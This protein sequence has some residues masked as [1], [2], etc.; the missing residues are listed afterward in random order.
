MPQPRL[1]IPFPYWEL[2]YTVEPAGKMGGKDQKLGTSTVHGAGGSGVSHSVMQGSFSVITPVFTLQVMDADDPNRIVR[3]VTPPGGLD[4]TLWT[5][6]IP[7]PGKRNSTKDSTIIFLL[8]MPRHSIP[9]LLKSGFRQN[10]L[11]NINFSST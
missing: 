3:T 7:V 9:I 10:I 1:S 4:S 11:E 8:S 6:L 2:W 5:E